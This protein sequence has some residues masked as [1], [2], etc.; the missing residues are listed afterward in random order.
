MLR[1]YK[2]KGPN[3]YICAPW[4]SNS[5]IH[6]QNG[7]QYH[8][9]IRLLKNPMRVTYRSVST[10]TQWREETKSLAKQKD[11]LGYFLRGFIKYIANIIN[12]N[13]IINKSIKYFSISSILI[14]LLMNQSRIFSTLWIFLS[15]LIN[16]SSTFP[17]IINPNSIIDESIKYISGHNQS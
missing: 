7:N 14:F 4:W 17:D 9:K 11:T 15:L 2:L 6:F 10:Q 13:S 12:P 1:S 5:F 16:Q 3:S 8:K